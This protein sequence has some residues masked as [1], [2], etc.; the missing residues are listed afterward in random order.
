MDQSYVFSIPCDYNIA[1][2]TVV[3]AVKENMRLVYDEYT[4]TT[5]LFSRFVYKPIH[6]FDRKFTHKELNSM[7]KDGLLVKLFAH[8]IISKQQSLFA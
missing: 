7:V 1:D 5:Y 4:N 3:V 8:P 2:T 6:K